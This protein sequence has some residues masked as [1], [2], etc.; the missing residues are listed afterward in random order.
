MC[1][2]C[3]QAPKKSPNIMAE[4]IDQILSGATIPAQWTA[5]VVQQLNVRFADHPPTEILQWGLTTFFPDI[6]L[7]TS[8]GPQSIVLMHL[9]SQIRPETPV[10]YLDTDLL[11]PET[12][13]LRDEL[14]VRLGLHFIR[15]HSG[16]SLETQAAQY[17]PALWTREPDLCCY[18]RKVEPLRRFLATQRAWITGIRRD[19]T[20]ARVDARLV[21]WDNA[22]GLVKLSPLAGWRIEQVWAYIHAT[23]CPSIVCTCRV[24]PVS[25]AGLAQPVA[26]GD[27]PRWRWPGGTSVTAA[28]IYNLKESEMSLVKSPRHFSPF[29]NGSGDAGLAGGM[30]AGLVRLGWGWPPYHLT[31]PAAHGPL[32]ISGFLGTLIGVERGGPFDL[33]EPTEAAPNEVPHPTGGQGQRSGP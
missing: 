31:L 25:A 10:F 16:L 27:D 33:A 7:A 30:W 26:S 29:P 21:E 14:A 24:I 3:L 8:F 2:Y 11:F 4:E 32:M 9:I 18:L 13:A 12:Y 1:Y 22:Y 15:V 5:E 19:Q 17:N 6:A 23:I 28:F 20:P